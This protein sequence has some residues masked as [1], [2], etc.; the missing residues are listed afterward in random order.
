MEH[1][2]INQFIAHFE[3]LP[4]QLNTLVLRSKLYSEDLFSTDVFI[5]FK[6]DQVIVTG[7]NDDTYILYEAAICCHGGRKRG[8]EDISLTIDEE[9]YVGLM[10]KLEDFD[11]DE[12]W[13]SQEI[14][15]IL[16]QVDDRYDLKL[17]FEYIFGSGRSLRSANL[18]GWV[19][20][21]V[22]IM[23]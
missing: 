9:E 6:D 5:Q 20:P 11:L 7:G 14:C 12:S 17:L 10:Q 23:L 13:D 22:P 21:S 18:G 4:H 19:C 16:Y 3:I 2:N 8:E 15:L 1:C